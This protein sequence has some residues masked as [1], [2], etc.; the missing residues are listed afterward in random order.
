MI[1]GLNSYV[2][3]LCLLPLRLYILSAFALLLCCHTYND[4]VMMAVA[5]KNWHDMTVL[6][7]VTLPFPVSRAEYMM[8][9]YL[10]SSETKITSG[11]INTL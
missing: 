7:I 2:L 3:S 9:D 10:N 5:W 4:D 8:Q 6:V 11:N 1:R